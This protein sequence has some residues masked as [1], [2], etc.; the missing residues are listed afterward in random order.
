[1]HRFLF[2]FGKT[3][4]RSGCLVFLHLGF[5]TLTCVAFFLSRYMI[6]AFFVGFE[7]AR[8]AFFR[9]EEFQ[10]KVVRRA[11]NAERVEERVLQLL[12]TG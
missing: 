11:P 2:C 9:G 4:T 7:K 10:W 6:L 5:R 12:Y 3:R 8:E 1:M